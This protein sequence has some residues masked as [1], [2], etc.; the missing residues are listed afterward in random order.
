MSML[1]AAIYSLH[2]LLSRHLFYPLVLSSLLA[3]AFYL[4]RIWLSRSPSHLFLMWNLFLAWVPYL[5]A[6]AI[7]LLQMR[8]SRA[9]LYLAPLAVWLLFFPNATYLVTDFYNLNEYASVPLWYDIGLYATCAW[10]G[11]LLAVASLMIVQGL[12]RQ[13]LGAWFSWLF[14]LAMVGLNGVGI[15][16]GRFMRWNSWDVFT[17]PIP[18]LNDAL[19][20][21]MHPI[22]HRGSIAVMVMF[23]AFL[24]VCYVTVMSFT[25]RRETNE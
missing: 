10:T 4:G 16:L 21:F 8:S 2:R 25:A 1:S 19:A 20:P 6:L 24:L 5:C 3:L 23:S 22:A 18:V 13:Y 9:W 15:Y 12:V 17:D 11:L 14:V 7:G